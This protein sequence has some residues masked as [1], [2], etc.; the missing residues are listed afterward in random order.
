MG[1]NQGLRYSSGSGSG[2]AVA[3]DVEYVTASQP[4]STLANGVSYVPLSNGAVEYIQFQ[5]RAAAT[6]T[7]QIKVEYYMSAANAGDVELRLDTLAIGAG[8]DPTASLSTGT[9]FTATPGNDA[10]LHVA[11][12]TT[13]S[14][15]GVAVTAGDLVVC[16]LVRT[17]D[18]ADTHTADMRVLKI[19][20]T[21]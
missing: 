14:S 3:V 5:F 13:H 11:D 8:E 16:K 2:S 4:A 15:L 1:M 17:N 21:A 12:S 9:E 6:T 7:A 10:L 20:V 18:A 19:A